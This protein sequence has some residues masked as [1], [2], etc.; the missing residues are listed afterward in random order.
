MVKDIPRARLRSRGRFRLRVRAETIDG[1]RLT[2][3][4]FL[5]ACRDEGRAA[6]LSSAR[7]SSRPGERRARPAKR[8]NIVVVMTDDQTLESMRVMTGVKRSLA[9]EGHDLRARLRLERA[10]LPVAQHALHGPV[11]AQ[12]RSASATRRRTAA[13]AGSTRAS[14]C[15]SGSRAPATGPCTS[16]SSSTATA[17]R[18]A[19]RG[20]A[21][22][23][24]VVRVGRPLHLP[25]L[26]LHAQRERPA[27]HLRARPQPLYYS[28]RLLRGARGV[29][30]PAAWATPRTPFFLSVAFLAPHSGGPRDADDPPGL[31]TPSPAPRHVNRFAGEPPAGRPGLQRGGRVGQAELHPARPPIGGLAARRSTRTT[32][33]GSSRCWRWTR[34]SWASW[35]AC[36]RSASST[37]P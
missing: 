7:S 3:D 35:T 37:T 23:E 32:S 29:G 5:R 24:R 25:V 15:R 12:P 10:L 31:P 13:T 11:L 1:R 18:A 2:L 30:D 20:A 6:L 33:S 28:D 9:A 26:R 8:P 36:G 19:H 16:A 17:C 34:P 21:R 27:L 14:G 4:R 22:L